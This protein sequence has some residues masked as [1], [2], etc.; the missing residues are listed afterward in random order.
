MTKAIL[1]DGVFRPIGPLPADW[2]DGTEV[3]LARTNSS[4]PE[5]KTD[6]W[7]DEV[8]RAVAEIDP[9]DAQIL[10]DAISENRAEA[11]ELARQ[12]KM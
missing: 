8:E 4:N 6:D 3:E 2:Q 12:G 9:E 5:S 10:Q 11:K 7:M 1:K